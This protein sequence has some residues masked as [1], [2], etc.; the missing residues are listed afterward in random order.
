MNK[1]NV[2]RQWPALIILLASLIVAGSIAAVAVFGGESAAPAPSDMP[3]PSPVVTPVPSG[4]PVA[5]PVPAPSE[6]P[7]AAPSD[8]V[9]A[10]P[11]NVV[12]DTLGT[13]NVSIDIVDDAFG[14]ESAVS[15]TPSA[16]ASVEMYTLHLENIDERTLRLTWVDRPGDNALALF[17]DREA[18]RIVLVQPEHDTDGDSIVLDRV[19]ILTF[20]DAIDAAGLE[21]FLQ[22]GLDTPG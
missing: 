14:V 5:T 10:M 16:S 7:S 19:L 1:Q 22:D 12:L 8:P 15:G 9:D 17:I 20:R 4:S 2:G 6:E 13:G 21:T 3:G 18:G 11:I